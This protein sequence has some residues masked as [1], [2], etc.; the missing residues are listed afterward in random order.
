MISVR[1][2]A[3]GFLGQRTLQRMSQRFWSRASDTFVASA[4]YYENREKELDSLL[5]IMPAINRALDQGCGDGRFTAIVAKHAKLVDA[6]DIS[7]DLIAS[8]R[9]R[10]LENVC[11]EARELESSPKA[12]YDLVT[13]MG[14]LSCIH[15]DEKYNR[16]LDLLTDCVSSPGYLLL[17]DTVTLKHKDVIRAYKHGHIGKYRNHEAYLSNVMARGFDLS[18]TNTLADWSSTLS[19]RMWLFRRK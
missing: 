9:K 4:G 17:V 10:N 14:V 15:E 8:A 11:F 1:T 5:R 7:S 3:Y 12:K 2:I 18:S 16:V 6:F 19:N 13:C